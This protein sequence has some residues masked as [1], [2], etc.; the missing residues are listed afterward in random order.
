MGGGL[1]IGWDRPM[2]VRHLIDRLGEGMGVGVVSR[3]DCVNACAM[4]A[5]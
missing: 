4:Y 1:I 5:R 2:W 3:G